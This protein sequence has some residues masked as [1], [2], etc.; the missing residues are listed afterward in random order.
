M[1]I[2]SKRIELAQYILSL[3]EIKKERRVTNPLGMYYRSNDIAN[4]YNLEP[5]IEPTISK[6][7]ANKMIEYILTCTKNEFMGVCNNE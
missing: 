4:K 7:F 1:N 6:D 3:T 5:Y 2:N